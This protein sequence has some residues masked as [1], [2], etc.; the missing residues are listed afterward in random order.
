MAMFKQVLKKI[1]SIVS[2]GNLGV[3]LKSIKMCELGNQYL[4]DGPFKTSKEYFNS[5]GIGEHIS[6]DINGKD[7][8]IRKDLSLPVNQWFGYFD[9]L[10]NCGTAEH[11]KNQYQ[12]FKNIHEMV[13][14]GGLIYHALPKIGYWENHCQF[15]YSSD[16]IKCLSGGNRY[17]IEFLTREKIFE[18][19]LVIAILRKRDCCF[20]AEDA[21]YQMN[22]LYDKGLLTKRL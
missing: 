3:P 8:A 19:V 17:D 11:V 20:M 1:T 5:I 14:V 9:V 12:L 13:R 7:G 4:I 15:H 6:L 2:D 16:F 18:K 10:T 21:F 22:G